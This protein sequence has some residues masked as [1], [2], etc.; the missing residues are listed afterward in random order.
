MQTTACKTQLMPMQKAATL[1]SRNHGNS[2]FGTSAFVSKETAAMHVQMFVLLCDIPQQLYK[3]STY[4]TSEL[5]KG[6]GR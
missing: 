6:N 5:L 3:P 2:L 4:F 1:A